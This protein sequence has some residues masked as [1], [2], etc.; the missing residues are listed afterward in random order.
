MR[1]LRET[2]SSQKGDAY[3]FLCVLIIFISMLLSV[4]V[5]YMGMT[6]QIQ[7]QKRDVQS[8]LDSYI[9][10]CATEAYDA[11]IQGAN[12]EKYI[13]W[14][15]L[16]AG[17]YS[18]LGFDNESDAQYRYANGNCTMKRPTVTVLKGD[19]FGVAVEYIAVFP[20]R[21]NGTVFTELEIPV[22]VTSYY[23]MK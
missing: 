7:A 6:A 12:R 11:L 18:A 17:A 10:E 4:V 21:W 23:K 20:I 15:A 1:Q 5:L 2:L 8:K 16:E 14:I 13:D 19:G 3:I 22:T 9:T